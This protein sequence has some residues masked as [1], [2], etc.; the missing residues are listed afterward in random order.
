VAGDAAPPEISYRRIIIK[1]IHILA[2]IVLVLASAVSSAEVVASGMK[3]AENSI[4]TSNQRL[5][6]TSEGGIYELNLNGGAWRKTALP[7]TF[8]DGQSRSCYYLGLV[9]TAG[10]VYTVCTENILNPAATSHLL[11]LDIYQ[12]EAHLIEVGVLQGIALPNGLTVDSSGNLYLADEGIPL[13]P[14][15]IH[16]I[17]LAG[18]LTIATQGVFHG[19]IAC[20]PN[21]LHYWNGKLY[22]STDP[23]SYF[24]LSQLLRYDLGS[25]GLSNK[26]VIYQSWSFLD[27]FTLV[28]GGAVVTE[29]LGER[30]RHISETGSVLHQSS[31][32]QP[33]SITLLTAPAFGFGNLLVTER[34]NGDIVRMFNNWGLQPR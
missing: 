33:T 17:T 2:A 6:V 18:S 22:V 1:T 21:G 30:I 5:F 26:K 12:P 11:G 16:K 31:F 14:G 3:N 10:M 19:F 25:N 34:S 28:N 15:A 9:E 27:D 8:K 7:V 20:K 24:G 23:S 32:N 4:Q 13:L 29:F